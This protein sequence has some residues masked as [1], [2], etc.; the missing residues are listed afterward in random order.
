MNNTVNYTVEVKNGKTY[1]VTN[2]C[3]DRAEVYASNV[4]C[5]KPSFPPLLKVGLIL[6]VSCL[7]PIARYL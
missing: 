6:S 3:T 2:T 7:S 1:E 4:E 5:R